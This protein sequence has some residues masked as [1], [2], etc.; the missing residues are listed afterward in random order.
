MFKLYLHPVALDIGT[1]RIGQWGQIEGYSN[2][3]EVQIIA[4]SWNNASPGNQ[5][6]GVSG[7]LLP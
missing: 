6:E 3:D 5:G 7:L 1:C 2:K 4:S